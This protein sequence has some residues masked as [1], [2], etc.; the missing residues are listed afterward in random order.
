M[1]AL[2][3]ALGIGI[4]LSATAPAFAED[5]TWTFVTPNGAVV[6][7]Q[8]A[9][10]G[11]QFWDVQ[12]Q[13]SGT[14]ITSWER[15]TGYW[16]SNSSAISEAN[17]LRTCQIAV[18]ES[19][20][21]RFDTYEAF[22]QAPTSK[23]QAKDDGSLTWW[24]EGDSE[25]EAAFSACK[26]E[27]EWS[28]EEVSQSKDDATGITTVRIPVGLFGPGTHNLFIQNLNTPEDRYFDPLCKSRVFDGG[29]QVSMGCQYF[30]GTFERISVNVEYP[31]ADT[32]HVIAGPE[33]SEK[34]WFD[35]GVYSDLQPVNWDFFG[36]FEKFA[37]PAAVTLG[38]T[39]V[40]AVLIALPT[41][42]LESS[43]EANQSRVENMLKRL[44]PGYG[45]R[46]KEPVGD[47]QNPGSDEGKS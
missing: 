28:T 7:I 30:K 26:D 40:F 21:N 3:L 25:V 16:P 17:A 10:D 8:T 18:K 34:T 36:N 13:G 24:I 6:P 37:G 9:E 38:V 35:Q 41:S 42:L 47:A 15:K 11:T 43:L 31:M 23:H 44:I 45:R 5:G 27:S 14:Y 1:G 20:V 39:S 29:G 4:P 12:I 19:Y 33:V 22:D 46:K 32:G 2:A